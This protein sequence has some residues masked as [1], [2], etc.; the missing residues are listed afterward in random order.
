VYQELYIDNTLKVFEEA[1][2][3]TYEN[4]LLVAVLLLFLLIATITDVRSL[5]IPNSLNGTFF[6]LRFFLIPWIGFSWEHLGGAMIAFFTLL[7][8]GMIKNHKMGGDIKCLT[9]VGFYLGAPLIIPFILLSCVYLSLY[10]FLS[11]MF[12]KKTKLLPFAPFFFISHI[13]FMMISFL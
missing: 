3:N 6:L 1:L 2:K 8:V 9:V 5:K 4:P 12:R 10:T 13:T 11:F 7:I